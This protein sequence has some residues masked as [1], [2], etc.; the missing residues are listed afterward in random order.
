VNG[1]DDAPNLGFFAERLTGIVSHGSDTIFRG[2]HRVPAAHAVTA[3]SAAPAGI[4]VGRHWDIDPGREVRYADDAQYAEHLRELLQRAVTARLRGLDRAAIL[5]SSGLDSASVAGVAS[6]TNPGGSPVEVR[7]YN[8]AFPDFPDADEEPSARRTAAHFAVPFVSVALQPATPRIHLERVAQL[9]DTVPGAL[10]VGDDVLMA[11][12]AR[13]GCRVVLSGVGGDEWFAG[14]YLHTA[15]MI[16]SGRILAGLQQLWYDGH[17]P[18]AF[19]G[20]GVLAK[21]CAWALTP[22]RIKRAVRRMRPAR[23]HTPPGFNRAFA[24][25]VSLAD[26]VAP[27]PIETRFP[28]LAAGAAYRAAMHPHG[29]YAWEESARQASLLGCELSAPLLD[30]RIAEFAAGVPEEQRWSGMQT[31]R[32]LRA[33]MAGLVPD[34][35]RMGQPK[36]DPGTALFAQVERLHRAGALKNLELVDARILDRAAVDWMYQEMVRLFA[37]G[38]MGYKV[39]AYRLSTFLGGD[40]VW[41]GLFGRDARATR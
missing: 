4:V 20:V 30:R 11:S 41:R 10:G 14:A 39:L 1:V 2:V 15:D 23:D 18:D 19:H 36:R 22:E 7:T 21:S 12:M 27:L 13:D 34:D 16:R 31:K 3:T 33:A 17:N 40:C 37:G 26:R 29:I 35:V 5:L 32:V 24:A 6:R 25:D 28:T 9:E 8:H 38:Q